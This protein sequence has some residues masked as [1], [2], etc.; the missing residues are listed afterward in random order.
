MDYLPMLENLADT[1]GE[2][3][4]TDYIIDDLPRFVSVSAD[5]LNGL[6]DDLWTG[7]IRTFKSFIF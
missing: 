6:D 3:L 2:M 1:F 7:L 4:P 5:Y